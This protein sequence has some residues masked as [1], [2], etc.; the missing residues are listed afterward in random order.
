MESDRFFFFCLFFYR[1]N[2]IRF[3]ARQ[4]VDPRGA[5]NARERCAPCG[6]V[7]IFLPALS[8]LFPLRLYSS[9]SLLLH[10]A[11]TQPATPSSPPLSLPL[12]RSPSPPP[13]PQPHPTAPPLAGGT[14][15]FYATSLATIFSRL[16]SVS[17][18]RKRRRLLPSPAWRRLLLPSR[19]GGSG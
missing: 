15:F 2:R 10:Y 18:N 1:G 4:S 17:S 6:R 8:L 16:L 12:H 11:S 13:L 14:L 9:S 5:E 7:L 3:F 19:R